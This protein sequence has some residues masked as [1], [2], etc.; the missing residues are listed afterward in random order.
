VTAR[1]A[2]G[3][4]RPLRWAVLVAATLVVVGVFV[5]V[6]LI[7]AWFRGAGEGALDAHRWAGNAVHG[8]QAVVLLAALGG[9]WRRWTDIGLAVALLAV[10][11]VQIGLA[12]GDGWVGGLH[13]LL[14]L[15]VLV[16]ATVIAHRAVRAL[17]PG[18]HRDGPGE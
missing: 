7:G 5:Q 13:G 14:A 8:L 11:T 10:G 6:Y 17:G 16:L 2:P 12:D 4:S 18:R 3:W 1:P 9:L 15:V